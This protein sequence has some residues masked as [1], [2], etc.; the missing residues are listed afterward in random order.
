MEKFFKRKSTFGDS[1][2]QSSPEVSSARPRI[3]VDIDELEVDPGK[4]K[5][6]YEYHINDRDIVQRRYLQMGPCQP[7]NHV[8]PSRVITGVNRRFNP[9]WFEDHSNWLEYSVSE[10]A[11]YCL[12]CYLFKDES[13]GQQAGGESLVTEGFNNWKK[14]S[15]KLRGHVGNHNS[16]H[17]RNVQTCR[18]L[19]TQE[20]HLQVCVSK[21]SEQSK[22]DYRVRLTSSVKCIRL[23]LRQGLAFRGNDE[24]Y[25]SLNR[26]NFLKLLKFLA[27]NNEDVGRVV[28]RNAPENHQMTSPYIQKDIVNAIASETTEMIINDL[29]G[30]LFGIIVDESRDISVKEQMI[31]FIRYVNSKFQE[32]EAKAMMEQVICEMLID[33]I[34]ADT[35]ETGIG[36]N[37]EVVLQR[38]GDTRWGSHYGA[39][40]SILK[41]F[42]PVIDVLDELRQD[43]KQ[44]LEA[45]R[46]LKNIL[47]FDFV[48]F[49]HLMKDVLEITNDLSQALQRKDQNIVNA[50][51]LVDVSKQRLQMMRDD[52]WE[53]LK[54]E[55]S[56]FCNKNAIYIPNMDEVY[57]VPGRP[58]R[59]V[60]ERTH[61]H[62]YRVERFCV[63]LDLQLQELNNRFNEKNTELLLCVACFDPRNS[64]AM[65]DKDKLIRLAQFYPNNFSD[66]ELEL[67]DNQLQSYFI[68]VS[69]D[70]AF[71]KLDGI[72]ELAQKRVETRRRLDYTLVYLLL[73]LS[74][75]LP[76]ATA[77][78]ERAFSAMKLIKTSLRN[79]MSD[80]FLHDCLVPYVENDVFDQVSNEAILQRFQKM[81][82]RRGVLSRTSS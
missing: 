79:R 43:P 34:S 11:A 31:V 15:E 78:V 75:I 10:D 33:S 2:N 36:L 46:V 7:K 51:R 69:S 16:V 54:R 38:P 53:A 61:L 27:D 4:R 20:Q 17:A 21:H 72:D 50:M 5:N 32:Y 29:G 44:R 52:G 66:I 62:R 37:Q 8:F 42:S 60:E 81:R 68:D 47:C 67:L 71:S 82:E 3:E 25:D 55:V 63:V 23:L 30:E 13:S 58:R 22:Q 6:I 77:S 41:L 64:F 80:D 49:L 65:F 9:K 24:S 74:L 39:L 1:S 18:D 76:V 19:M 57:V 73:K 56:L 14:G 59:N 48:F 12:C 45:F 70:P 28:M 40:V 26:G 35:I